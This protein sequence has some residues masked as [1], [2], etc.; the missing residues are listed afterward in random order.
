MGTFDDVVNGTDYSVV[1]VPYWTWFEKLDEVQAFLRDRAKQYDLH[2]PLLRDNL[3]YCHCFIERKAAV[4][5]PIYPLVDLI[6]SFATCKRR[7]FMSAT[8]PDDSEIIRTFDATSESLLKPL[9]SKSLAGLSERMI[10]VPELLG[11][12]VN[13]VLTTV[14]ALCEN[15]AKKRN[16]STVILVPS[17]KRPPAGHRLLS[18]WRRRKRWR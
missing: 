13:D 4:V 9:S 6:P 12:K 17:G 1:E 18:T 15:L 3:K 10:L 5:T 7:V 2:W 16:L 8:I 14:R 11:F